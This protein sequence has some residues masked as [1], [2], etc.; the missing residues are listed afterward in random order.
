MICIGIW[1]GTK[2]LY[3][4]MS[5]MDFFRGEETDSQ[6]SGRRETF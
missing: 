1:I 4:E 6:D 3:K 5:I 2:N